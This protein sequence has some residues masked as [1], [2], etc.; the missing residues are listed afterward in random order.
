MCTLQFWSSC[1]PQHPA[2]LSVHCTLLHF[3]RVCVAVLAKV[4]KEPDAHQNEAAEGDT[5]YITCDESRSSPAASFSWNVV[6]DSGSKSSQPLRTSDRVIV[7]KDGRSTKALFLH[8]GIWGR[9]L[10]FPSLGIWWMTEGASPVSLFRPVA[11]WWWPKMARTPTSG[12]RS[13][14]F[15]VLWRMWWPRIV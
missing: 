5:F 11:G 12:G 8:S 13:D 10:G 3:L 15:T 6:D 4:Q 1:S 7:A 2:H 9:G 14:I